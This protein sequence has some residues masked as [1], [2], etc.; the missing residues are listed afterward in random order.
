[1][2]YAFFFKIVLNSIKIAALT[3]HTL[4]SRFSAYLSSLI[5]INIPQRPLCSS[6]LNSS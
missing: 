4:K 2:V 3:Y 1:M 5:D 6:S